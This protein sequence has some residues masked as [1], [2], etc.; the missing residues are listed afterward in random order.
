MID[1]R[2]EFLLT[3]YLDG[4]LSEEEKRS[5]EERLVSDREAAELLEEYRL[6]NAATAAAF[7]LPPV[8]WDDLAASISAE[9]ADEQRASRM[10][11]GT[12][13][14]TTSRVAIAAVILLGASLFF[15]S[16]HTPPSLAEV[17]GPVAEKPAGP[18]FAEVSISPPTLAQNPSRPAEAYAAEAFVSGP[19]HI[20]VF[21]TA[22]EGGQDSLPAPWR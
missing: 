13:V 22:I 14:R 12:W 5:V 7:E 15:R 9:I 2:F 4:T 1:E 20:E 6:L 16:G 17:T 21:A 18:S 19:T 10:R 3:Q 8:R 11:I